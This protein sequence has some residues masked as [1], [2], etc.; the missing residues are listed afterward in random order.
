MEIENT[1]TC[2]SLQCPCVVFGKVQDHF[3]VPLLL[4]APW[5]NKINTDVARAITNVNDEP[6]SSLR[7]LSLSEVPASAK[8]GAAQALL[9]TTER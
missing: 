5:S 7:C 2:D 9:K 4:G 1:K 6:S 3:R 8:A